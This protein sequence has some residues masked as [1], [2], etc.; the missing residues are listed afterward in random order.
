MRHLFSW[1]VGPQDIRQLTESGRWHII[2]D[3]AAE[4]RIRRTIEEGISTSRDTFT[5]YTAELRLPLT[6]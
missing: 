5:K 4:R 3:T 6:T 2:A 1:L